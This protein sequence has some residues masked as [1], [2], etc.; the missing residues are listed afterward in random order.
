MTLSKKIQLALKDKNIPEKFTT[1]DLRECIEYEFTENDIDNL[2]NY[3][4]LSNS[5]NNQFLKAELIN[6]IK[7]YELANKNRVTS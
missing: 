7:Y 4:I 6:D 1:V 3:D 5:D 2:A